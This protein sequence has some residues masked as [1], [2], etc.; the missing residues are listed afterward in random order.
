MHSLYAELWRQR[1]RRAHPARPTQRELELRNQMNKATSE[2]SLWRRWRSAVE[3]WR[4]SRPAIND[5]YKLEKAIHK[6]YVQGVTLKRLAWNAAGLKGITPRQLSVLSKV[7]GNLTRLHPNVKPR[8]KAT[9]RAASAPLNRRRSPSRTPRRARSS[10]A[11][12]A[13]R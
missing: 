12:S 9:R 6:E 7:Q 1:N 13:P 5:M 2:G 8:P 10:R 3:N 11:A 4:H